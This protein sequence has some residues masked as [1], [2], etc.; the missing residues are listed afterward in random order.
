MK[1]NKIYLFIVTLF[2]VFLAS[3]SNASVNGW[4]TRES[5]K[6]VFN[7]DDITMNTTLYAR[8]VRDN[9]SFVTLTNTLTGEYIK[10]LSGDDFVFSDSKFNKELSTKLGTV[11]FKFNATGYPDE[12][13][14]FKSTNT[15]S[16]F[17]VNGD[18]NNLYSL[19]QAYQFTENTDITP[20]FSDETIVKNNHIGLDLFDYDLVNDTL[21][22]ICFSKTNQTDEYDEADYDCYEE[23]NE[24]DGDVTV[25]L[26]WKDQREV[27]VTK[28]DGTV[29]VFP[30]YTNYN[31][32]ENTIPSNDGI[33][34]EVTLKYHDDVHEDEVVRYQTGNIPNGWIVTGS[35]TGRRHIDDNEVETLVESIVIEPDYEIH[36]STITLPNPTR[37]EYNFVGWNKTENGLGKFY[38]NEELNSVTSSGTL[39]LHAILTQDETVTISFDEQGGEEVSDLTKLVGS[40]LGTLPTTK[41]LGYTFAGWY[42]DTT[43]S[44]KVDEHTIAKYDVTYYARWIEDTF[45]DLFREDGPV[46]FDGDDYINTHVILY[47]NTDDIWK[48]DYEI[49]LTIESYDHGGTEKQ[50]TF[51]SA[52]YENESLKWPG[53]VFRKVASGNKIEITQTINQT[54]SVKKEITLP[55]T[56]P[57]EVRIRREDG[58]VK[59]SL[60]GSSW[61]DLQDMTVFNANQRHDVE[62]FFGAGVSSDGITPFRF[63][64]ATMSNMYVKRGT[65]PGANEVTVTYPDG[66]TVIYDVGDTIDLSEIFEI[67][68]DYYTLGTVT[69]KYQD[70]ETE[71]YIAYIDASYTQDG[72]NVEGDVSGVVGYGFDDVITLTENIKILPKYIETVEPVEFPYEPTRE[73]YTF[74]GWK[75]INGTTYTSY[76]E[77]DDLTL[78]AEWEEDLVI[79]VPGDDPI[80]APK[81]STIQLP[82]NNV[83]KASE[84]TSKVTFKPENGSSD[85]ERYVLRAYT[86]NG[87][88]INGTHYDV[89]DEYVANEVPTLVPD[90]VS[91]IVPVEFPEDPTLTDKDFNGWY[92]LA[93]GGDKITSYSDDENDLILYAQYIDHVPVIITPDG[94]VHPEDDGTYTFKENTV[95]KDEELL[96][97]VTFVYHNGDSD[98]YSYVVKEYIKNGWI[99]EGTHYDAGDTITVD[100]DIE[101]I[102]DYTESIRPA[103]FPS[104]P[105]VDG[106]TFTG[107]FSEKTGGTRY[108]AYS[109]SE[110][111]T[112]HAQ[113][114]N[115]TDIDPT[116]LCRRAR[117]LHTETCERTGTTIGCNKLGYAY[118][119]TI[120]YGS[121]GNGNTL[122]RGD[123]FTCDVNGDGVF[124]E[125]HERFYYV[126]DNYSILTQT[127]DHDYAVML[128]YG[129]LYDLGMINN[130]AITYSTGSGDRGPNNI[131]T[132]L[133]T[134]AE[135]SNTSLKENT[136][137]IYDYTAQDYFEVDYT[138]Y[139]ARLATFKEVAN[140]LDG[141]KDDQNVILFENTQF[142]KRQASNGHPQYTYYLESSSDGYTSYVSTTH[143]NGGSGRITAADPQIGLRPVIDVPK[144]RIQLV[145]DTYTVSIDGEVVETL[146]AGTIYTI[147]ENTKAKAS[148]TYTVTFNYHNESPET[149]SSVEVSYLPNGYDVT[150]NHYNGGEKVVITGNISLTSDYI[151][152]V[153]PATFPADPTKEDLTFVGWFDQ[154]TGGNKFTEYSE[155][156]DIILHAQYKGDEI[157]I[158]IPDEPDPIIIPVTPDEPYNLPTN[159]LDKADE[160]VGSITFIYNDGSTPDLTKHVV[161][162]YTPNGW[163]INDVAYADGA[164]ITPT[165][166]ITLVR[167]YIE[168]ITGIE[169]PEDPTRDGYGFD[170]WYTDELL[171]NK[172]NSTSYSEKAD[173]NLYA[174]WIE[175]ED[176]EVD[177]N[178][179]TMLIGDT[180][181]IE[182]DTVPSGLTTNY[183]FTSLDENIAT[184]N[185][186]GTITAIAPGSVTVKVSLASN[187]DIYKEIT[188]TVIGDKLTSDI[189][190]VKDIEKDDQSKD[191]IVIGA[192]PNTLISEFKANMTN[193]AEYIKIYTSEGE[194]VTDDDIIKTGLVIKL[195][196]ND[197]VLDEAI[198][199]LRG[200]I[201][202]DGLIDVTDEAYLMDHILEI[203]LIDDYK[204]YAADFNDDH[205]IDVTDESYLMDYILEI[206]DSLNNIE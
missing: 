42:T 204:F 179:V 121:L 76:S 51:V 119:D 166:D 134:T 1:R 41:K 137:Y 96:S 37:D 158:I 178:N 17:Y 143:F 133:P 183:V 170:G 26:H 202:G 185:D 206:R 200:D 7:Y 128:Y 110:D 122:A 79:P 38:T 163:L 92:T 171:E 29:E 55:I 93:D 161:A 9:E 4:K 12:V 188:V 81:G 164:E 177:A 75:D 180:H 146:R 173:I 85:I 151:E 187:S 169:W 49:G 19:D 54:P 28:P 87:W 95:N 64:K 131:K 139:A 126:N 40:E 98:S 74:K 60:N 102:P 23:Y 182:V 147:P 89:G 165:D 153:I 58:I 197:R 120:T 97:T 25:Y 34:Y 22:P 199:I 52:K 141:N 103:V 149:T 124:D 39:T 160:N 130:G 135:W 138:G 80:I 109:G 167:N 67:S 5:G 56:Y 30:I 196:Y 45:P 44:T 63:I 101:I 88:L 116:V 48:Q 132:Y 100:H 150:D 72:W 94:P 68:K 47:S 159:D 117:T 65:I 127:Y 145:D 104:D 66:H 115:G 142:V 20:Y 32:G 8:Y 191:R 156:A 35:E 162:S 78:Y 190:T 84:N 73:N 186:S 193:P 90:Y 114:E 181:N 6:E 70:E 31:Y 21:S 33:N 43:Y 205:L 129:N 16:G 27:S 83:A 184:V 108:T 50:G 46:E 106:D 174:K 175:I 125:E 192:E 154:E 15:P 10:V 195:E 61:T 111:I 13:V 107:W 105:T 118:G 62:T 123:A 82:E 203:A 148:D 201:D 69:F 112:L 86:P 2:T 198:I 168:T 189:Y 53:I 11:T 71:D 36:E 113:W 59:Y 136:R 144:E 152:T 3:I 155:K 140:D 57:Y 91:Y 157:N 99:A 24:A 172:Y 14:E 194:E 176:I 77:T 18:T